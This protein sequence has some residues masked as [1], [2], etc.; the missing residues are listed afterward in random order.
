MSAFHPE[1]AVAVDQ[2]VIPTGI[3]FSAGTGPGVDGQV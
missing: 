2:N 1:A 3:K